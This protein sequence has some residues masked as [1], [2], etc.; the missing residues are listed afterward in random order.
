MQYLKIILIGWVKMINFNP[1]QADVLFNQIDKFSRYFPFAVDYIEC[2]EFRTEKYEWFFITDDSFSTTEERETWLGL[3]CV[4]EN[5]YLG[6]QNIHLSV[7]EV[8]EPLRNLNIGT[9]IVDRFIDISR[10]SGYETLSLQVRNRDLL[11][12]YRRFGFRD[13]VLRGGMELEVLDL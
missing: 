7:L 12:F 8:A 10:R 9:S 5:K 13:V 1:I 11:R 2:P 4:T 3:V 6:G